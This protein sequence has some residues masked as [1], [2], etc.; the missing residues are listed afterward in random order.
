[1]E[2]E[3]EVRFLVRSTCEPPFGLEILCTTS[4]SLIRTA[5]L[6]VGS[7]QLMA[8]TVLPW[9]CFPAELTLVEFSH[10]TF[11]FVLAISVF[12]DPYLY[13]LL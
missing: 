10:R 3:E 2:H 6:Y 7:S 13:A 12:A 1:M 8:F 9:L 11:L 4:D 5:S